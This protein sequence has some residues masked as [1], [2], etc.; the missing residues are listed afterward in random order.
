M[1][2]ANGLKVVST[3]CKKPMFGKKKK[4]INKLSSHAM[5]PAFIFQNT[6]QKLALVSWGSVAQ[7]AWNKSSNNSLRRGRAVVR[8]N[9]SLALCTREHKHVAGSLFIELFYP[10]CV[11]LRLQTFGGSTWLSQPNYK[12]VKGFQRKKNTWGDVYRDLRNLRASPH[13]VSL[14]LLL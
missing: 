6:G 2:V 12:F 9:D 10:L 13:R 11:R 7:R 5:S 14:I 8:P 3:S 1:N 4:Q